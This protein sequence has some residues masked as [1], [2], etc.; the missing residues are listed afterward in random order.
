MSSSQSRASGRAPQPAETIIS[1]AAPGELAEIPDDGTYRMPGG[2][3]AGFTIVAINS[4]SPQETAE[5]GYWR[6][7]RKYVEW[8]ASADNPYPTSRKHAAA[9]LLKR[10]AQALLRNA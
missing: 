9:F 4:L 8:L 2:R 10:R 3:F 1:W 7:G 6:S 5:R